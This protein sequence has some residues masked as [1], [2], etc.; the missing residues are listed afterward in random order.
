MPDPVPMMIRSKL[1]TGAGYRRRFMAEPFHRD[2]PAFERRAYMLDISRDRVPTLETLEWL[3]AVLQALR[4]NELQ[5][6]TEHTFSYEGHEVV[7][8]HASR[9]WVQV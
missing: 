6:Y 3:V 4:F 2:R 9:V 1:R 5:L 8:Q 7:W